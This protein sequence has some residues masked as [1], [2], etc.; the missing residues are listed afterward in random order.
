[1]SKYSDDTLVLN[2]NDRN[3]YKY[4][5]SET[6]LLEDALVR[7]KSYAKFDEKYSAKIK[8]KNFA[9]ELR[10]LMAWHDYDVSQML[11]K[12]G[13]SKSYFYQILNN[14]R[15]PSRDG[16]I[17]IA[18]SL[19][20][21]LEETNFLLKISEKQELYA[22][23]KRDSVIIYSIAHQYSLA[24]TNKLLIENEEQLLS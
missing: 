13:I 3:S 11:K 23:N 15:S 1:M 2:E 22:K 6:E 17:N 12:T 9:S 19:N 20:C 7:E 18:I 16:V 24:E 14:E 8:T 10:K 5:K 4:K 21:D